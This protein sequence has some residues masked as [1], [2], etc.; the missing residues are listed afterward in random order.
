MT[1]HVAEA[2]TYAPVTILVGETADGGTRVAY[3]T[4]ASA[5]AAY[6]DE[7]ALE[8]AQA[9]DAER[10]GLLRRVTGLPASGTP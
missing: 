8:I 2:G 5:L 4:V 1:R 6:H 10:L 7:A 3:D 9:L